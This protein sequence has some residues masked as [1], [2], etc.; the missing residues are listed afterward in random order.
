MNT[1]K[2]KQLE[3]VIGNWVSTPLWKEFNKKYLRHVQK[4][5]AHRRKKT[6]VYPKSDDVFRAFRECDPDDLKVIILGQDPYYNGMADG[7]A[8]SNRG[9]DYDE[10]SPSLKNIFQEI[11][12]DVGFT[13]PAPDPDLTRWAQQ[14]VLLLNTALTVEK[15][16]PNSH[17]QIPVKDGTANLWRRF[18]ET[19]VEICSAMDQPTVFMLWGNHAKSFLGEGCKPSNIDPLKPGN[20]ILRAY[21]PS[22]LSASRGFFGCEHF[23]KANKFLTKHELDPIDW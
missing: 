17:Q 19:A 9:Y 10:C 1:L 14:G 23:S 20:R 12:N 2:A 3:S 4:Y 18:T 7:L 11:E 15:G 21:H 13:T 5:I 6:N 16:N 22:P 8:F